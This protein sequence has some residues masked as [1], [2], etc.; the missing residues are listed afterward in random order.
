MLLKEGMKEEYAKITA[1]VLAQTDAFG[2]SSH[3]TKN[4]HNYLRKYRAGG[5]EIN[6][7]PEILKEGPAY[8]LIDSHHTMG[9]G[10][11]V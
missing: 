2:T 8:A 11:R 6:V 7:E 3:G 1:E 5:M 4:L 9:M 10:F